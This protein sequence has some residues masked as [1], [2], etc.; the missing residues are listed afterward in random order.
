[1]DLISCTNCCYR[2]GV[3]GGGLNLC[4]KEYQGKSQFCA[5]KATSYYLI[6]IFAPN[7]TFS[8]AKSFNVSDFYMP[9]VSLNSWQ[10]KAQFNCHACQEPGIRSVG[11]LNFLFKGQQLNCA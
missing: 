5:N 10:K 2:T 8:Q 7:I 1:M 9:I 11:D 3:V 4:N 6:L